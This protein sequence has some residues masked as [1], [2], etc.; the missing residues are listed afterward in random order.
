V[1]NLLARRP[2]VLEDEPGEQKKRI[3]FFGFLASVWNFNLKFYR[4][5]Y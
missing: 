5:V 1:Y 3:F 4:F 2:A